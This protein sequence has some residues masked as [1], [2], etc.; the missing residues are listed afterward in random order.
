MPIKLDDTTRTAI[1][2]GL[3]GLAGELTTTTTAP[4]TGSGVLNLAALG[5]TSVKVVSGSTL[6]ANSIFKV[7]IA[8]VTASRNLAYTV[9][10]AGA[11]TPAIKADGDGSADEGSLV[12]SS[13]GGVEFVSISGNK[14]LWLVSA[15]SPTVCQ[16]TVFEV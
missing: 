2:A 9:V 7:K 4:L 3:G 5:A 16:V 6:K 12:L 14:D 15:S 11:A 8:C 10:A 13:G 1:R